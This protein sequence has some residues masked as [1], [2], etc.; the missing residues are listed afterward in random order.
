MDTSNIDIGDVYT[1][2]GKL[3]DVLNTK[4]KKGGNSKIAH[5]KDISRYISFT[6]KGNS[7]IIDNVYPIPLP[8]SN[9]ITEY[10]PLIERLLLNLLVRN[11]GSNRMYIR[12]SQLLKSLKM[13]NHKYSEMK[14]KQIRLSNQ[15]DIP[16]ETIIDFYT[17]S[18]AILERNIESAL[19]SL[20]DQ[21]LIHW[22]EVYSVC[23]VNSDRERNLLGDIPID[24]IESY[25]EYDELEKEYKMRTGTIN[26]H[27]REA[28]QN[29]TELILEY[30]KR[31]LEELGIETI[32]EI[33]SRG[34]QKSFFDTVRSQ[35]MKD[36][37]IENYYKSYG[38]TFNYEHVMKK[39]KSVKYFEVNNEIREQLEVALNESIIEKFNDNAINRHN[40]AILGKGIRLENRQE[41][42][43]VGDSKSLCKYL[44]E[45]I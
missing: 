7:F 8:P 24:V 26:R 40:D 38:I 14:Y 35:L 43:Y 45:P 23:T 18:D 29:E 2:Y 28:T 20:V 12:K 9:S 44:V 42:R 16:R 25:N 10:I 27:H 41:N 15:Y 34:I 19:N 21:S 13:V 30:Q 3:C 1:S 22:Q 32:S 33:Y 37:N 5:I 6:K 17:S 11:N 31:E 36:Y 39:Y 4:P